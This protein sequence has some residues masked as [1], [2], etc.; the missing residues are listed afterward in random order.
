MVGVQNN[1]YK[2]FILP[3]FSIYFGLILFFL[4]LFLIVQ[5]CMH[6]ILLQTLFFFSFKK[7]FSKSKKK[8]SFFLLLAIFSHFLLF[9][10]ETKAQKKKEEQKSEVSEPKEPQVPHVVEPVT[11]EVLQQFN[12]LTLQKEVKRGDT[13]VFRILLEQEND[14]LVVSQMDK[15]FFQSVSIENL[16]G[17]VVFTF[18]A[19]KV[20]VSEIVIDSIS[21][22]FQHPYVR[23]NVSIQ[24]SP[25]DLVE[26]KEKVNQLLRQK[27]E[28]RAR[29]ERI[30]AFIA[31][32]LVEKA[33]K[34]I[35]DFASRY[36]EVQDIGDLVEKI[37]KTM[38]ET[39]KSKE[40]LDFVEKLIKKQSDENTLMML[41]FHFFPLLQQ[42]GKKKQASEELLKILEQESKIKKNSPQALYL[43]KT[44][45]LLGDSLFSEKSYALA[46]D[47]YQQFI[48]FFDKR[49]TSAQKILASH[50]YFKAHFRIAQSYEN[51]SQYRD[52]Q[53]AFDYYRRASLLADEVN[54]RDNKENNTEIW[55]KKTKDR[56]IFLQEHFL[57]VR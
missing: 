6:K 8:L 39:G 15:S 14:I 11:P 25:L 20:G 10:Q 19:L 1:V 42:Q 27:K 17:E 41:R 53:K 44:F 26:K 7:I 30:K 13:F 51:D 48:D 35:D 16:F 37:I 55:K 33:Q 31:Q 40:A 4:F 28:M 38:V 34:E 52:Y 47:R 36:Q 3:L 43:A 54:D 12:I 18:R 5:C 9:S 49:L 50:Q 21:D 24:P 32:G 56:L 45:V 23:Y 57:N 22:H 29:K 46:R 2:C